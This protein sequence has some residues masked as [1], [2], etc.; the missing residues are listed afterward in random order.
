MALFSA[1]GIQFLLRWLH[2]LSGITWIGL[3]YYFNF[4]QGPF[5]AEADASTRSV[6]TQKLVPRALWWFRWSAMVTFLSGLT[7]LILRRASWSDPWGI[8][9]LTGAAFGTVMFVNVWRVIWPNQR[10]V[11]ANAIATAG[12]KAA[13]PAA[14]GAVSAAIP[15][16]EP[17][18]EGGAG[19]ASVTLRRLSKT[20]AE[21]GAGPVL[22]DLSLDVR[23]GE[24]L[25]LLGPSGS[26][27]TTLLKC[28][29]GLEEP[30]AGEILIGERNVTQLAPAARDVA[31]VFQHYALYPHLTVRANIAFGLEVRRVPAAEVTRR[32][33]ETAT[34]LGIATLLDRRPGE[35][36]GGERQRVALGRAVVREPQVF[37]FDEPLSSLDPPLRSELRAEVLALH[38]TL[39]ATMIYVTQDQREAMTMGQR[40]AV[41]H[42][43]QLR[44]AGTPAEVYERPA[45]VFVARFVGN[46]GMNVLKGRGR[47]TEEGSGM[48]DL[49]GWSVAVALE[50]YEGEIHVGVRP[51][52]VTLGAG[53][54]ETG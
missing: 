24:F 3:L 26:G 22:R 15:T 21:G 52:H 38:A 18:L 19:M 39:G 36:S 11:I 33:Q 50:H 17:R 46:P 10:T 27:K 4:V 40:I 49:G 5:F 23:D 41:L 13:N 45:D 32:V 16:A 51:E 1:A 7:I 35:L 30:S 42:Q 47:G 34:R 54:L 8:T 29:A 44:Q 53:N 14:A 25:A 2:F 43:G 12:G 6:A 28:I 9:I 37:L 31:L 48:V 20:Y